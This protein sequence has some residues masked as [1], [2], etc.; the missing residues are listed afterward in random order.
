MKR[1]RLYCRCVASAA[2]VRNH[3]YVLWF[4]TMGL[5]EMRRLYFVTSRA[6]ASQP[7][8]TLAAWKI[9]SFR[10]GLYFRAAHKMIQVQTTEATRLTHPDAE[11]Q[12]KLTHASRL[13]PAFRVQIPQLSKME[14][15]PFVF[16][17]VVF[18]GAGSWIG[19]SSIWM[20]MPIFTQL[21][22]E[23]WTLPSQLILVIQV[24]NCLAILLI[25]SLCNN[26]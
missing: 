21:L 1:V 13:K 26:Q 3:G 6:V 18:F 2:E 25:H 24:S 7:R 17:L 14:T 9:P 20:E 10:P 15:N 23:S 22:P 12:H 16:V 5:I 8:R 19:T 11:V 4:D